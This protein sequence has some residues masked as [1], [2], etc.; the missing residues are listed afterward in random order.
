M[1]TKNVTDSMR[2]GW[3]TFTCYCNIRLCGRVTM[4]TD[5]YSTCP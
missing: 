3:K 5:V 2:R 4:T 1:S